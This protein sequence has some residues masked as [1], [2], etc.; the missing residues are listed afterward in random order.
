[1]SGAAPGGRASVSCVGTVDVALSR[2]ATFPIFTPE[3]ERLWIPRWAPTYPEGGTPEPRGGLAFQTEKEGATATWLV[4]RW[5]PE[6]RRA[7]YAYVL[8]VKWATTVEVEVRDLGTGRSR[9]EVT[10]HVT[11][12]APSADVDV[13]ALAEGYQAR[14]AAWA[15]T[16]AAVGSSAAHR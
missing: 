1:M 10:Y 11:S 9:V 8:P 16:L 7:A 2:Q 13:A 12:L 5:E 3:G 14:L 4:T 6:A 15:D